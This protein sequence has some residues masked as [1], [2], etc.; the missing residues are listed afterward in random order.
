MAMTGV[1]H[2]P[3]NQAKKISK[4]CFTLGKPQ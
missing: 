4:K 1:F 3:E 2:K